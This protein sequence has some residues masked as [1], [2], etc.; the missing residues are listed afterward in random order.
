MPII[1]CQICQKEFY[2][3]P[4]HL[5][6][7]DGKYCSNTCAGIGR[8]RGEFVKCQTC[9]KDVWRMPLHILRSKS[10]KYF[11]DKSCQTLWRNSEMYVGPNHPNWKGGLNAYRD[12]MLRSG[13]ARIC[14]R[15][16]QKD[17]RLL[18]VHHV[19][20]NRKN[21]TMN[22]LIWLCYNCHYLIHKDKME[23]KKFMEVLV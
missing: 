3:K 4:S 17:E 8:R 18:A 15:C 2:I 9:G 22:N 23:K 13:L 16:D 20:E 7:G 1:S 19:D 12:M 14:K 11:C 21:N 10:G 6:R 5:K